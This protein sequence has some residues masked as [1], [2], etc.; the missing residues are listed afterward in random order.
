MKHFWSVLYLGSSSTLSQTLNIC[1][2]SILDTKHQYQKVASSSEILRVLPALSYA[3]GKVEKTH[4]QPREDLCRLIVLH[5]QNYSALV[6]PGSA[7]RPQEIKVLPEIDVHVQKHRYLSSECTF[8]A[9]ESLKSYFKRPV[10]F[11]L[12]VSKATEILLDDKVAVAKEHDVSALPSS[13]EQTESDHVNLR[14]VEP[15]TGQK[16][17]VQLDTTLDRSGGEAQSDLTDGAQSAAANNCCQVETETD[18]E[19][20]V[21]SRMIKTVSRSKRTPTASTSD[22]HHPAELIVS[23]TSAESAVAEESGIND[24]LSHFSSDK[25]KAMDD[26]T[27]APKKSSEDTKLKLSTANQSSELKGPAKGKKRGPRSC[28]ETSSVQVNGDR[29]TNEESFG[30]GRTILN[31]LRNTPARKVQKNTLKKLLRNKDIKYFC[32]YRKEKRSNLG[33][34]SCGTSMNFSHPQKKTE[35]WDLKPV[36]SECGRILVPHGHC[37]S[38]RTKASKDK[39][40]STVAEASPPRRRLEDPVSA[41]ETSELDLKP[42]TAEKEAATAGTEATVHEDGERHSEKAVVKQVDLEH[43]LSTESGDEKDPLSLTS[44]SSDHCTKNKCPLSPDKCVAKSDALLSKL[45]SVLLRGKRKAT[46]PAL[47]DN[48]ATVGGTESGLKKSKVD[49]P[50]HVVENVNEVGCGQQPSAATREVP[51]RSVDPHFASALG[52]T[53][54][55]APSDMCANEPVDSL[56]RNEPSDKE[57]EPDSDKHEVTANF[58]QFYPRR[59]RIK[60]LKKHQSLSTELVK[61]NC[62]LFCLFFFFLYFLK[63]FLFVRGIK[64]LCMS[65]DLKIYS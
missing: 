2:L 50:S 45:K 56:Q 6:D 41:Q 17:A 54:K 34:K 30:S 42:I 11:Q 53:P 10:L 47:E 63:S 9:W 37:D 29:W 22:L 51:M 4:I 48:A 58:H 19:N 8:Q 55:Q 39:V 20:T 62:K 16:S 36:V 23:F 52:L 38:G 13:P 27:V 57:A 7:E 5:M 15:V 40:H 32:A 18:A 31:K 24:E 21:L 64:I 1:F 25:V 65:G 43:N 12:P 26:Q 28:D 60:A 35:R 59:G 33:Q 46:P 44:E 3:E 14:T 61:K 49:A